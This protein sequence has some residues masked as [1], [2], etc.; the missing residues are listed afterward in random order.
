LS[1]NP[2]PAGLIIDWSPRKIIAFDVRSQEIR[3]FTDAA[4]MPYGGREAILAISRRSVFVRATRVP[5]AAPEDVRIVVQMK[6]AELFPIPSADLAFD[7]ALLSDVSDEGRLALIVAMPVT[8]L[9]KAMEHMA[10]AGIKVTRTVPVALGS[11]LLADSLGYKDAAVVE[12][13]EDLASV[14]VIVN[15]LLRYSRVA[16]PAGP[17][18]VEIS[19]TF[20]AAGVPCSPTIAAGGTK[21]SEAATSTPK[22][23]LEALAGAWQDRLKI[24]LQLPEVIAANILRERHNRQWVTF[25]AFVIAIFVLFYCWYP[26]KEAQDIVDLQAKRYATQLATQK[27]LTD[28][29]VKELQADAGI[30]KNL[31]TAFSPAQSMGDIVTQSTNLAPEGVWLSGVSVERG[32]ELTLRGTGTSDDAVAAYVKALGNDPRF[33][34]VKL[35]FANHTQVVNTTVVQFSLSAFPNGN[36][37]IAL[38]EKQGRSSG[39]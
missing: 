24:N 9:R 13:T 37:P 1:K 12:Q 23:A 16:P 6:L 29:A 10:T 31:A 18:D 5:N 2:A 7:F 27:K 11:A 17:I 30:E 39:Q 33:R 26:R 32:K 15:G 35:V 19:R 22:T 20:N 34:N 14:D 21:V 4:G 25:L 36:L 3:T 38:T 28:H 8:E